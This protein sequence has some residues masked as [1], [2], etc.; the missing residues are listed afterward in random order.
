MIINLISRLLCRANDDLVELATSAQ[1]LQ[2]SPG[3][4]ENC[5]MA[6]RTGMCKNIIYVKVVRKKK[7]KSAR[8][9]MGNEEAELYCLSP[10]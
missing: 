5:D 8:S 9:I 1:H 10:G 2:R 7:K 4:S 6:A 3:L